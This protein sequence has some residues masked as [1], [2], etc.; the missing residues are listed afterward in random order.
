MVQL[1]QNNKTFARVFSLGIGTD[2]D[3]TL[4]EGVA[5]TGGGVCEFV[6]SGYEKIQTKIQEQL[7]IALKPSLLKAVPIAC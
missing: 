4:I 1:V 6:A 5:R 2:V 7:Q 3:R